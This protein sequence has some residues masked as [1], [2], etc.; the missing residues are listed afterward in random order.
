MGLE[1]GARGQMEKSIKRHASELKP[2]PKPW[3]ACKGFLKQWWDNQIRIW[4]GNGYHAVRRRPGGL[5]TQ[6]KQQS[7]TKQK[8]SP[9]LLAGGATFLFICHGKQSEAFKRKKR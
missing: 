2:N 9:T 6:T 1:K 7:K 3:G 5:Y 8:I 4:R